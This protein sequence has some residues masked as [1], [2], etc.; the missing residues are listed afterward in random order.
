MWST[1]TISSLLYSRWEKWQLQP[2]NWLQDLAKDHNLGVRKHHVVTRCDSRAHTGTNIVFL[3]ELKLK[4]WR[5]VG[6]G[7]SERA[8]GLCKQAWGSGC[9]LP[10]NTKA[11]LWSQICFADLGKLKKVP[12]N[13]RVHALNVSKRLEEEDLRGP[14]S[15]M[16]PLV[17]FDHRTDY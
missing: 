12:E 6:G 17:S 14:S 15:V 4:T 5:G 13:S 3:T 7:S 11:A 2:G 8:Q 1:L 16:V 9:K 10:E